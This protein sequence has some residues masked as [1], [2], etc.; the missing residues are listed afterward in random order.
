MASVDASERTATGWAARD[1]DG[2]LSPYT[3]TLR[4]HA[5]L[6]LPLPACSVLV[7]VLYRRKG[8]PWSV[9]AL[10]RIWCLPSII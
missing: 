4:Y 9:R 1:A 6:L 3:Y 10:G 7:V 5:S 8:R 2:H